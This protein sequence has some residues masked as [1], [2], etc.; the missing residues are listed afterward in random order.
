M[1]KIIL[2]Y[3]FF[4]A[5]NFGWGMT[6]TALVESNEGIVI[7]NPLDLA[8]VDSECGGL[9]E[10]VCQL[11]QSC[12]AEDVPF[13]DEVHHKLCEV[14]IKFPEAL[15]YDAKTQSPD[16]CDSND[17]FCDG[18]T[19]L[20]RNV[21]DNNGNLID[22]LIKDDNSTAISSTESN[23]SNIFSDFF[24]GVGETFSFVTD[25]VNAGNFAGTLLLNTFTGGFVL[26]V[27]GTGILGVDFPTEFLTGIKILVGLAVVSWFAYLILGKQ[28]F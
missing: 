1:V 9:G 19:L 11:T 22:V 14:G 13:D 8:Y 28:I 16:V 6:A 4:I 24:G 20:Q 17:V 10:P 18:T 12:P 5:I 23:E 2:L 3:V 15:E 21:T 26:D 27:L 25:V 7:P